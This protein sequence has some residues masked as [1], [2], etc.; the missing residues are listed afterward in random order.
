MLPYRMDWPGV[1]RR[2]TPTHIVSS[3]KAPSPRAA[4]TSRSCSRATFT[5]M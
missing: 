1:P 3:A 5:D 4:S 2:A